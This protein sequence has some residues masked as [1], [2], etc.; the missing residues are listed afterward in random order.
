MDPVP[1]NPDV[2]PTK[3][4]EHTAFYGLALAV[5]LWAQD[6]LSLW[7][8]PP[9]WVFLATIGLPWLVSLLRRKSY[10]PVKVEEGAVVIRPLPPT[11]PQDGPKNEGGR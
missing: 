11:M 2:R 6:Q 8:N 4:F 5:V 9:R 7:Q 3:P 1:Q 10:R